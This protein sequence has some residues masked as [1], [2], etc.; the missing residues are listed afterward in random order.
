MGTDGMSSTNTILC[1][2]SGI[3]GLAYLALLRRPPEQ[4]SAF[5][6]GGGYSQA[7][8]GWR[9]VYLA[10]N[11][12]FP[13]GEREQN[14]L[15]ERICALIAAALRQYPARIVVLL[16]NTATV[17]ALAELRRRL[18]QQ[19]FIGTVPAIKLAAQATQQGQRR[20]AMLAS[21][22]TSRAPYVDEL[23]R[24]YGAACEL[25]AINAASLIR[26]IE[27][28]WPAL[29]RTDGSS[30]SAVRRETETGQAGQA[31]IRGA[32]RPFVSLVRDTGAGQ[33]V[34]G[35]THF[36]HLKEQLQRELQDTLPNLQLQDSLTG[37]CQRLWS[38]LRVETPGQETLP[39]SVDLLLLTRRANEPRWQFWAE[40]FALELGILPG[41][42]SA[43]GERKG[44][45]PDSAASVNGRR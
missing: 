2:D 12:C 27:E 45:I 30:G 20:I 9:W 32:I 25:H 40:R 4:L 22:S 1:F 7:V 5:V 42:D 26:F 31:A 37:V 19:Q 35:C 17:L 38:L 13:F 6:Q 11:A 41:W 15:R 33:L 18:P 39:G 34:L 43:C 8:S 23:R 21:R 10:D 24:R 16:C 29:L 44:N 14:E 28:D 3:G 36:L